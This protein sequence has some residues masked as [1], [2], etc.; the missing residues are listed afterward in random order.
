M[1]IAESVAG[2][3][4]ITNTEWSMQL[5]VATCICATNIREFAWILTNLIDACLIVRAFG[6]GGTFRTWC[7]YFLHL[8]Q[9]LVK[10]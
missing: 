5:H 6:V 4:F 8:W 3:T 9:T 10:R 7:G 2:I 1:A